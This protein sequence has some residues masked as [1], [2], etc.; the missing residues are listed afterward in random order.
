[1]P[2]TSS[3]A[4]SFRDECDQLGFARARRQLVVEGL[5]AGFGHGLGLGADI[6]FARRIVADENDGNP[7]HDAAV[8]A[9]PVHG[10]RDLAAQI[11]GDRLSVNDTR[12][13][14]PLVACR[15]SLS[16]VRRFSPA[17]RQA[18]GHRP[19]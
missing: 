16:A 7:R 9:Q 11:R 15:T 6:D 1:M 17:P 8:A 10:I 3:S 12:A 14:D 5:H 13:H 18:L 19:K 2:F 4:L